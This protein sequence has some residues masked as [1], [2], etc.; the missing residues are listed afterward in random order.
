MIADNVRF[1]RQLRELSG[2]ACSHAEYGEGPRGPVLIGGTMGCYGDAY[3]PREALPEPSAFVYHRLHASQLAT[4]GVDFLYGTTLPALSEAVGM[5]RAMAATGVPYVLSFIIRSDGRLLDGTPLVQAIE[6]IDQTVSP[7]P[8]FYM[9]N[10]VHPSIL[11][12][13]LS[14]PVNARTAARSRLLGIQANASAKSPEELDGTATLQ[15]D[16]FDEWVAGMVRLRAEHRLRIFG[17]CCGTN[18]RYIAR[19]VAALT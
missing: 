2:V 17:G 15:A 11:L 19:L 10:C 16:D 13:A 1:V 14:A 5:A 7:P 9:V 6:R 18:D 4:A 12:S 3:N 8:R